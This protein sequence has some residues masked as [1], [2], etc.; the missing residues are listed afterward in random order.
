M[1]HQ[2]QS[3]EEALELKHRLGADASFLAGGTDLIVLLNQRRSTAQVFVDLTHIPDF[4]NVT[5]PLPHAPPEFQFHHIRGGATFARL[6]RLPVPA[7][8]QAALSVGGPQI[9]NR[10]TL[11]GNLATASPAGDGSTALLALDAELL[12]SNSSATRSIPIQDFFLD[13]R[14]TAL[15]PD[16]IIESIRIPVGWRS[17]WV[18]LGKRGTMNISIVCCA[19]GLSPSGEF[20][21]AF[22]SVGPYPLRTPET[23]R[24]LTGCVREEWQREGVKEVRLRPEAVDEA[25]RMVMQEVRPIDDFRAGASYRRAMAAALLRKALRPLA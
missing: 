8:A 22:G 4:D 12:L 2:P 6:T 10:A 18:K 13:Y 1:F 20:R 15:A 24:F 17:A 5:E 9:R 11:A 21:I 3:L 14:K 16:E 19:V 25:C 23:E 7:L